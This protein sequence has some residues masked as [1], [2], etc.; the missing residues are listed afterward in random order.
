MACDEA[1]LAIRA[2]VLGAGPFRRGDAI[3]VNVTASAGEIAALGTRSP[4]GG[5]TTARADH[6]FWSY[7]GAPA[8]RAGSHALTVV[9][10]NA[11]GCE[12]TASVNVDLLGDLILGDDRGRLLFAGSD[13]SLIEVFATV[14]D[15]RIDA[16][17]A[18]PDGT[19][20]V[21]ARG[22]LI[23][24]LAADGRMIGDPF[25]LEFLGEPVFRTDGAHPHNLYYDAARDRVWS[26]GDV[27]F[28]HTWNLRGEY[29]ESFPMGFSGAFRAAIGFAETDG[30]LVVGQFDEGRVRKI[31]LDPEGD[32][33]SEAYADLG[34]FAQLGGM[35]NGPEGD[36]LIA[37]YD[38]GWQIGRYG[39]AGGGEA[40]DV[41]GSPQNLVAFGP[42]IL[43]IGSAG[44]GWLYDAD[45]NSVGE[46][47]FFAREFGQQAQSTPTCGDWLR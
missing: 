37:L 6:L 19:Y 40:V 16:V 39:A 5:T 22:P 46:G 31:P 10:R 21:G 44:G 13:G 42:Y 35:T 36:V 32:A 2:Q 14:G 20:L 11:R 23:A 43:G 27:G 17:R 34:S 26:D 24:H 45:F 1:E 4:L 28:V 9:A 18:L 12:A 8:V 15:M 7:A 29:Q 47:G 38:S 3:R 30:W 25:E 33:P 41:A